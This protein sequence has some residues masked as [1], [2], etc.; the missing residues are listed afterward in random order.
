MLADPQIQD[1]T[2][3]S[4]E[5]KGVWVPDRS[6]MPPGEMPLY[7]HIV[8]KSQVILDA[9]VAKVNELIDQEL[10]PLIEERTLIARA[11]ATGQPLPPGVGQRQKWPEEKLFIGL[12]P[13]R[14][15]NIRAKVVGPGVS[16]ASGRAG[17]AGDWLREPVSCCSIHGELRPAA[18]AEY[19]QLTTRACS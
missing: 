9:A 12:D 14:N 2:G 8:A 19:H 4:I 13:I 10:G 17:R 1:E 16:R 18:T 6:R 11:R 7:L 5:T 15:F 3:A